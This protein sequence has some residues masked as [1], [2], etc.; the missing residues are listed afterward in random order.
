MIY[1][2]FKTAKGR[3]YRSGAFSYSKFTVNQGFTGLM[4]FIKQLFSK[5]I[6]FNK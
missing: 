1:S 4:A 2:E 3:C 5:N 6:Y